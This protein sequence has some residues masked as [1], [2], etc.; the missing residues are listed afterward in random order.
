VSRASASDPIFALAS[1]VGPAQRAV[2]RL[3]GPALRPLLGSLVTPPPTGRGASFVRLR[4]AGGGQPCLLLWMPGPGSYTGQDVAE[5]HLLGVAPLVAEALQHLHALGL[6]SAEPGEFTRRAFLA[7][8][9][10]LQRAEGVLALVSASNA[11]ERRAAAALYTSGVGAGADRLRSALEDLSARLE[12]SLDFEEDDAGH[13]DGA[14][15]AGLF[16]AARLEL[17]RAQRA[18]VARTGT[19]LPRV[20]LAGWPN[21]GKSR[22]FNRLLGQER[23]LVA[24]LEGTTRDVL[25]A[26]LELAGLSC[27]LL[28]L[29]GFE[30]APGSPLVA[31]APVAPAERV[32]EADALR[33]ASGASRAAAGRRASA[34]SAAPTADLPGPA[35]L[36]DAESWSDADLRAG[37]QL[38]AQEQRQGLD[39]ELLVVDAS[40][41]WPP[42]FPRPEG[43][44]WLLLNQI[45]RPAA[46]RQPP[47]DWQQRTGALN[48]LAVSAASGEGLDVLKGQLCNL[49]EG[50]APALEP[51]A[52]GLAQAQA[53][54]LAELQAALDRAE[55]SLAGR[56]PLDWVAEDLRQALEALG[57]VRGRTVTE[58]LLDRIF[59]RFCLGK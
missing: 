22:L 18:A 16:A 40:R 3:S 43:P 34:G 23:A 9:I 8:R 24:D 59:A 55:Q 32:A 41:P 52:A 35:G 17:Q 6:R 48:W 10:D 29:P 25:S 42:E 15:L 11:A 54:G 53:Q 12:A 7:G 21:A 13:V 2:V 19:H 26:V 58:D 27:W 57:A 49:L 39:L 4:S 51:A 14:E 37:T 5:L 47:A 36:A 31:A 30:A 45:D 28:D 20:G 44:R 56:Q 1:P 38:R 46:Q 50:R 33:E